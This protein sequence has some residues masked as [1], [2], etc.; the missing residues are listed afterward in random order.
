MT[1]LTDVISSVLGSVTQARNLSDKAS[2]EI[3]LQYLEDK[4]LSVFPVPRAD[5]KEIVFDIKF[6]IEAVNEKKV[7][8]LIAS[9][10]L[11]K[12]PQTSISTLHL[13]AE[14]ENY[15][16]TNVDDKTNSKLIP[17]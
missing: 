11:E 10:D 8:V 15:K 2:A 3:S 4:L 5:I 6:A 17:E 12:L 14:I 16:W 1:D 13:V 7:K 9:S